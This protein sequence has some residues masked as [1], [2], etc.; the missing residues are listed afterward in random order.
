ME[1]KELETTLGKLSGRVGNLEILLR[2]LRGWR[3]PKNTQGR[4]ATLNGLIETL[5]KE[6]SKLLQ[7]MVKLEGKSD[8][9]D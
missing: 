2:D 7:R 6:D 9:E 5:R 4:I 3:D 8:E 1:L